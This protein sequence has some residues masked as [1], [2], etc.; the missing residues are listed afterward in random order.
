LGDVRFGPF[1]DAS[2]GATVNEG[3][4]DGSLLGMSY[5]SQFQ[6]TISGDQMVLR[7]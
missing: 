6:I 1:R 2:L 3:D 5:L 4:M 7:R